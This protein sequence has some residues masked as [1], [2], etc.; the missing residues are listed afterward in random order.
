MGKHVA[1]LD[2]GSS[3]IISLI[4]STEDDGS[5]VVRGAG[6]V[7]YAGFRY[8]KILSEKSFKNAIR[9][10]ITKA[11]ND[12]SRHVKTIIVGVP[13]PFSKLIVS[14][15]AVE[16]GGKSISV[17]DID[18]M[19]VSSFDFE[20]PAGFEP[21]HDTPIEFNIDGTLSYDMPLG[22]PANELSGM[23]SHLYVDSLFKKLIVDVLSSLR[24]TA[25]EF[26]SVPLA[27]G[28]FVVSDDIGS[29]EALVVDVGSMHTDVVLMRNTAVADMRTLD[30]GGYNF[31][32]DIAYIFDLPIVEA[33]KQKRNYVYALDY[34]DSVV[35]IKLPEEVIELNLSAI[36]EVID[37]RT[38]ELADMIEEAIVSMGVRMGEI[39]P[40]YLT[41]GGISLMRGCTEFIS[42]YFG[43]KFIVNMPWMPRL[44]SPNYASA[45][46]LMRFAMSENELGR[47][48]TGFWQ[49]I[50]DFLT[51]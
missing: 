17:R 31:T 42:D 8:G 7:G 48:S 21:I 47:E 30:V 6:V 34:T 20:Q 28:R 25:S 18:R 23:V 41:G 29:G 40:I 27:E 38:Y 11:E 49:K 26:I 5:F 4:C 3:K 10:A 33:E 51:N 24:I 50:K 36:S 19:V 44:S 14:K 1:I 37:A 13:S 46:A 39:T 12:A 45:F 16:L 9:D 32:S 43:V 2:I 35:K 15:G 22:V